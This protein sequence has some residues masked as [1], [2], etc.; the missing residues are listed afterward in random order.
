MQAAYYLFRLHHVMP[1]DFYAMGYG[2]KLIVSTFLDYQ[3]HQ[4]QEEATLTEEPPLTDAD[5]AQMRKEDEVI[6][7]GL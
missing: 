1:S 7:R 3:I 5:L 2:E 4:M 6:W